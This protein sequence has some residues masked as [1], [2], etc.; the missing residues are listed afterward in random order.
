MALLKES[1]M[2]LKTFEIGIFSRLKES[3]KS[4]Q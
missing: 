3:K 4:K 2:V 1:K